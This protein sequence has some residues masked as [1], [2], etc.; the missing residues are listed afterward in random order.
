MRRLVFVFLL[1]AVLALGTTIRL[2]LTDGTYQLTNQ[3]QVLKD[4]VRFYSTERSDWEEI[5]LTLVDLKRTEAEARR[6]E[7]QLKAETAEFSAEEKAARAEERQAD[8]VPVEPGVY[9]LEGNAMKTIPLAETAVVN[10]KRRSILKLL[11]PIPMVSGKATLEITGAHSPNVFADPLQEFYIRLAAEEHFGIIKLGDHKGNRVVEQI[12]IVPVTKQ[13]VE[14]QD[15]IQTFRRQLGD[16]LYKI[17]PMKP[18][19]PGEYAVVEYTPADFDQ[20]NIRTWDF[21]YVAKK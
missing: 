6:H 1:S 13:I 15:E 4:R 10:D 17:W 11:S 16:A 21:S 3:Y 20:I 14:D 7:V 5:P 9:V 12:T 2:Y 19:E 8:R 18:L